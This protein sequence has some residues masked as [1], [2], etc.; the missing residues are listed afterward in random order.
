MKV[1]VVGVFSGVSKK[2]NKPYYLLHCMEARS[3][4]GL[5]GCLAQQYFCDE[6]VAK[7]V[8]VGKM[9][10]LGAEFGSKTVTQCKAV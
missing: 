5:N 10:E 2:S 9:Y 4:A 7:S 3:V 8:Q 6:N 1:T